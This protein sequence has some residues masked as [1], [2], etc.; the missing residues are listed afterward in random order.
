MKLSFHRAGLSVGCQ[1]A[2]SSLKLCAQAKL[3]SIDSC[4]TETCADHY[5]T[6]NNVGSSKLSGISPP[7][8]PTTSRTEMSYSHSDYH[9][10]TITTWQYCGLIFLPKEVTY[11]FKFSAGILFDHGLNSVFLA[12]PIA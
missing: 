12:E 4:Q 6:T 11:F 2:A 5:Q 7:Q 10:L 1:S 8:I 9:L 3:N